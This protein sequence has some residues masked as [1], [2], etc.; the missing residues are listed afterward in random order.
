MSSLVIVMTSSIS[1]MY[2][3]RFEYNNCTGQVNRILHILQ[4]VLDRH[5]VEMIRM[6]EE[7]WNISVGRRKRWSRRLK[8]GLQVHDGRSGW[9]PRKWEKNEKKRWIASLVSGKEPSFIRRLVSES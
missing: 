2:G 8:T 7:V 9:I 5:Y 4:G 3:A 6:A 1:V